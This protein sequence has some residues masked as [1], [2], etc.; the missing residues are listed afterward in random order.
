MK[1]HTNCFCVNFVVDINSGQTVTA[2]RLKSAMKNRKKSAL[3]SEDSDYMDVMGTL[4]RDQ[5]PVLLDGY[6]G[7]E[8][9]GTII[10][11]DGDYNHQGNIH[12]VATTRH[13][14]AHG[15]VP[16]GLHQDMSDGYQEIP[17]VN[18][19][20]AGPVPGVSGYRASSERV[21]V[22]EGSN[23]LDTRQTRHPGMMCECMGL[24]M[25]VECFR[26][27][28]ARDLYRVLTIFI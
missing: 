23:D 3:E 6:E 28:P 8:G 1:L 4:H 10:H 9:T 26:L 12:H 7:S 27:V 20:D 11:V 21:R 24:S 22:V 14:G 2:S 13:N 5:R 17:V 25:V 16:N 15:N 19:V 18:G